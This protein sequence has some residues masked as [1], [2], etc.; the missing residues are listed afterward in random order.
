MIRSQEQNERLCGGNKELHWA[1]ADA[2]ALKRL[3][4]HQ[5]EGP[6]EATPTVSGLP[7]GL[8]KPAEL[9]LAFQSVRKLLG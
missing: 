8:F 6:A 2:G 1:G 9:R 7:M 3:S 5:G 4:G